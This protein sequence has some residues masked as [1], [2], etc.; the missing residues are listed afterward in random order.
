MPNRSRSIGRSSAVFNKR[1]DDTSSS[2]KTKKKPSGN[3]ATSGH[4]IDG[5]DKTP[6]S[7]SVN[8]APRQ[9]AGFP[10]I[11][12][13]SSFA[14]AAL[15]IQ[16]ALARTTPKFPFGS[17]FPSLPSGPNEFY[18]SFQFGRETAP[19]DQV[20]K[21][22][23]GNAQ[24][25]SALKIPEY[26][27]ALRR[28]TADTGYRA[29][30][31]FAGGMSDPNKSIEEQLESSSGRE[32]YVPLTENQKARSLLALYS[33]AT[34]FK[35]HH[36][37]TF[38]K[39]PQLVAWNY[40]GFMDDGNAAVLHN[41]DISSGR[42]YLRPDIPDELVSPVVL[43][44]LILAASPWQNSDED[45]DIGIFGGE[46]LHA[47]AESLAT[48]AWGMNT[49]DSRIEEANG[50]GFTMNVLREVSG[51]GV[52]SREDFEKGMN[53][54]ASW[55]F[56]PPNFRSDIYRAAGK[57]VD[58]SSI[59]T[60]VYDYPGDRWGTY[61]SAAE[62][63]G[64]VHSRM[65]NLPPVDFVGDNGEIVSYRPPTN[66][67][68]EQ[69]FKAEEQAKSH[70]AAGTSAG[71]GLAAGVASAAL[72]LGTMA[73]S[74]SRKE[75][76]QESPEEGV[77]SGAADESHAPQQQA[78]AN[79]KT[80]KIF[81]AWD[82][83][84]KSSTAEAGGG[85]STKTVSDMVFGRNANAFDRFALRHPKLLKN[86]RIG[87]SVSAG[88][89]TPGIAVPAGM[90]LASR[91]DQGNRSI[92][93]GVEGASMAGFSAAVV[94][95]M[96]GY[97]SGLE[98]NQPAWMAAQRSDANHMAR[99]IQ[100][101]F[102]I[103]P[104][105]NQAQLKSFLKQN[106]GPLARHFA[107]LGTPDAAD[108]LTSD[109]NRAATALSYDEKLW[110]IVS[111]DNE[112]V[113]TNTVRQQIKNLK[114]KDDLI[115]DLA[116]GDLGGAEP[117]IDSTQY[118][119]LLGA[120]QRLEKPLDSYTQ[121]EKKD[122]WTKLLPI[123]SET[124]LA[125]LV[126][127]LN[128]VAQAAPEGYEYGEVLE[129][130]RTALS[131]LLIGRTPPT[132]GTAPANSKDTGK[133][134][135]SKSPEGSRQAGESSNKGAAPAE[136]AKAQAK[137]GRGA[138]TPLDVLP[139]LEEKQQKMVHIRQNRAALIRRYVHFSTWTTSRNFWAIPREQMKY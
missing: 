48:H 105:K 84:Q 134:R 46:M 49:T 64:E 83:I 37:L 54:L 36:E 136:S 73:A 106:L 45:Y 98:R 76:K 97:L 53:S 125:H 8:S 39:I 130:T 24:N 137:P 15:G 68:R 47:F 113:F 121:D 77:M 75:R 33:F 95:L 131:A 28:Y 50:E 117:L 11:K 139:L 123:S 13:I 27:S 1:S 63:E 115:E 129:N 93:A 74:A 59:A 122:F 89:L 31:I 79:A 29:A 69:D 100:R 82:D 132:S 12:S 101:L 102:D 108:E 88:V 71:A 17:P 43:K 61:R 23:F 44:H 78:S 4:N 22:M 10:S 133:V 103:I 70:K 40:T 107:T 65:Q 41:S 116:M 94:T 126:G 9:H 6:P 67:T 18:N 81:T 138:W 80:P 135:E 92:L 86:A 5:R 7:V 51:K 19:V 26:D 16:G 96:A 120:C 60:V 124:N 21:E 34:A 110:G 62:V 99:S 42:I 112:P 35:A 38:N 114:A 87:A 30:F 91:A 56:S 104:K 119:E 52:L 118:L 90:L 55:I 20:A 25:G 3:P 32:R 58:N 85:E 57:V 14:V 127:I 2:N 66:A 72:V 111:R 128:Q 109:R